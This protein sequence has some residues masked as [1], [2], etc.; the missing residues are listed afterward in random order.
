MAGPK[1][2]VVSW[3]F[4]IKEDALKSVVMCDRHAVFI[5]ICKFSLSSVLLRDLIGELEETVSR[6]LGVGSFGR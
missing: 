1:L 5:L 2:E 4:E 6:V 3:A